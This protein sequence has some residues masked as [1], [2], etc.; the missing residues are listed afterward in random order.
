[1]RPSKLPNN[2]RKLPQ[3]FFDDAG[4]QHARRHHL[5]L[6]P[7]LV[8]IFTSFIS[9]LQLGPLNHRVRA[10]SVTASSFLSHSV[11]PTPLVAIPHRMA[12]HLHPAPSARLLPIS[13]DKIVQAADGVHLKLRFHIRK[14]DLYGISSYSFA[15]I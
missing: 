13:L 11:V 2:T 5:N 15:P 10:C 12:R 7:D 9:P 4:N 6:R 1:M 14:V 8:L 3:G